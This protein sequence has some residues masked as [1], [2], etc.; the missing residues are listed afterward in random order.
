MRGQKFERLTVQ[1]LAGTDSTGH[2][3][4]LCRCRCSRLVEVRAS[5]LRAGRTR[6]CGCLRRE[7]M[8]RRSTKHGLYFTS[9]YSAYERA[10]RLVNP[11]L[12]AM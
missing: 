1:K 12:F 8:R 2:R 10:R 4:C 7:T 6:S 5:D 9:K 3:L 11:S